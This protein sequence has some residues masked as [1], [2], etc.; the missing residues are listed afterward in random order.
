MS[1]HSSNN[2][3]S[4]IIEDSVV[5]ID[6]LNVNKT[7]TEQAILELLPQYYLVDSDP[8]PA[9]YIFALNPQVNLN[10]TSLF[11][12]FVDGILIP[13]AQSINSDGVYLYPDGVQFVVNGTQYRNIISASSSIHA[14][15][16]KI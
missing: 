3:P 15:Y 6:T 1:T 2:H 5:N 14:L 10:F 4:T 12:V 8:V 9:S 7:S 11:K 13:T 16:T